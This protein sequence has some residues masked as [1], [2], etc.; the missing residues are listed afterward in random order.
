MKVN[1]G[2]M[3]DKLRKLNSNLSEFEGLYQSMFRETEIARSYWNDGY[4]EA[5][6][7]AMKNEKMQ[8]DKLFQE[9]SARRD[10]YQYVR[11]QYSRSGNKIEYDLNRKNDF[12]LR[13]GEL[14]DKIGEARRKL[15]EAYDGGL[16]Y[17]S[18]SCAGQYQYVL[19]NVFDYYIRIIDECRSELER[20]LSDFENI[21]IQTAR[22][23]D[24][25]TESTFENYI[26]VDIPRD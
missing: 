25:L 8:S 22:K 6:S 24:S 7:N 3:S 12:Y 4:A 13:L 18:V 23:I 5:F 17:Y 11:D 1:V 10:V 14:K 9:L 19:D 26:P 2:E 20:Y 15:I 16:G 21:E